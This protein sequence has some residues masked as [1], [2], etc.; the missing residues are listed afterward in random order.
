[1]DLVEGQ[2]RRGDFF[3]INILISSIIILDSYK[4]ISQIK[5]IQ[6]YYW[7]WKN[8]EFTVFSQ[9]NL[10]GIGM[11]WSLTI[12][13]INMKYGFMHLLIRFKAIGLV[14][15]KFIQ[16]HKIEL[17][18]SNRLQDAVIALNYSIPDQPLHSSI[19]FPTGNTQVPDHS[20]PHCESLGI[21][22]TWS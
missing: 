16:Q 15:R 10:L 19:T 17:F 18:Q 6:N 11:L 4:K 1:M 20:E 9:N 8:Q 2:C 22:R 12:Q 5:Y 7:F 21:W 14:G 3:E 13:L